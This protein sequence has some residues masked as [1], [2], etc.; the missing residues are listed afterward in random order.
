M[1]SAERD[2]RMVELVESLRQSPVIGTLRFSVE[3]SRNAHRDAA[4]EVRRTLAATDKELAT[5]AVNE[6][7]EEAYSLLLELLGGPR[8]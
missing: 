1:S 8:V 4:A 5:S 2:A 3:M 7:F 6:Q